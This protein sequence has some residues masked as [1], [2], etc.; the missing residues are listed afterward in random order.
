MFE[1][2]WNIIQQDEAESNPV[3][4]IDELTPPLVFNEYLAN[5]ERN[6]KA[7]TE[8][9][10]KDM[11]SLSPNLENNAIES[12]SY[13]MPI[14]TPNT[15]H[16]SLDGNKNIVVNDDLNI[17]KNNDLNINKNNDLN[18]NK[19]NPMGEAQASGE[20]PM[21]RISKKTKVKVTIN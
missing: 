8:P 7:I 21:Q 6:D 1:A 12:F 18:I 3:H 20:R 2:K 9:T 19:N 10:S 11:P 16:G 14:L 5:I 4:T 17:N 13:E 15:G